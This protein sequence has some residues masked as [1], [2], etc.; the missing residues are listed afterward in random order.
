MVCNA[1]SHSYVWCPE[2][3]IAHA[4]VHPAA[5]RCASGC[6]SGSPIARP[7]VVKKLDKR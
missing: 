7:L 1:D 3:R 5:T 4:R 2:V 6:A